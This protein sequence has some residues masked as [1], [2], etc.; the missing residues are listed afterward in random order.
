MPFEYWT[1]SYPVFL[2]IAQQ[3]DQKFKSKLESKITGGSIPKEYI[4]GV[5]KGIIRNYI[6]SKKL[7]LY[8]K[9]SRLKPFET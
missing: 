6:I 7:C 8:I 5:E 3:G 2:A 1:Y 9:W 4:P